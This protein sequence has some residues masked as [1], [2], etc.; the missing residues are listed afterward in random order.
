MIDTARRTNR[1]I[2][3]NFELRYAPYSQTIRRWVREGY[4]GTIGAIHQQEMWD[5]HKTQGEIGERRLRAIDICGSLGCGIHRGDLVRFFTG[6]DWHEIDARGNWFGEQT[7]LPSHTS[8]LA[9]TSSGMVATLN[10]S[11]AYTA[12]IPQTAAVFQIS[13]VGS[14]GVIEYL[15]YEL[16]KPGTLKIVS[17]TLNQTLEVSEPPHDVSMTSVLKDFAALA[18]G[19]T[20]EFTTLAT[21]E[22]G[23]QAQIFFDCGN[24]AALRAAKRS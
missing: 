18:M 15:Q 22:D 10:T 11:F 1:I 8:V 2:G 17:E 13:L 5:C 19:K 21:A 3:I 12:F 6:E 14:K 9:T 4:I 16:E 23:L 20:S 24:A 7:R